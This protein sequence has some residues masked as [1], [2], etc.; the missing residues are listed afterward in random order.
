MIA[1]NTFDVFAQQADSC[2]HFRPG[3]QVVAIVQ[4]VQHYLRIHSTVREVKFVA[5]SLKKN[6]D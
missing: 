4:N 2:N 3:K 5:Q 1:I 6:A